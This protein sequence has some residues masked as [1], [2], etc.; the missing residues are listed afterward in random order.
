MEVDLMRKTMRVE[1]NSYYESMRTLIT[2]GLEKKANKDEFKEELSKKLYKHEIQQL[3]WSYTNSQ[4]QAISDSEA[5]IQLFYKQF[6]KSLD[7]KPDMCDLDEYAP[8]ELI[9]F[10]NDR[11]NK[12]ESNIQEKN[13]QSIENDTSLNQDLSDISTPPVTAVAAADNATFNVHKKQQVVKASPVKPLVPLEIVPF[14]SEH[15]KAQISAQEK[16]SPT[17]YKYIY[18]YIFSTP[19]HDETP[20]IISLPMSPKIYQ[21][22]KISPKHSTI[23]SHPSNERN[24]F[25]AKRESPKNQI[26]INQI[27]RIENQIISIEKQV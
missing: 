9:H 20:E 27:I 8:R 24:M 26:N 25:I 10:L 14:H 23:S 6:N 12:L 5:K 21:K 18:I 17:D 1:I 13:K 2:E 22:K 11:I 19:T 3:L 7:L 16:L 4:K 15:K